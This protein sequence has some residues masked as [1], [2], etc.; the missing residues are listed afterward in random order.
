MN[1]Q[2]FFRKV[3]ARP[4]LDGLDGSFTLAA[5]Y[6]D[7][8]DAAT[9]WIFLT[10]FREWLVLKLGEGNNLACRGLVGALCERDSVPDDEQ[11]VDHLLALLDE[12]LTERSAADGPGEILVR[13]RR[14]L[15][16]QEWFDPALHG[17][18]SR[19]ENTAG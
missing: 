13:H 19:D 12:F 1:R 8:Y 6:L 4:R 5:T 9:D 14:W 3:H 7:G 15:E 17:R 18:K 11:R 16:T 10:G 2:E